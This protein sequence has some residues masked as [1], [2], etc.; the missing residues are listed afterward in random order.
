[1]RGWVV[2]MSSETA[3]M[4]EAAAFLVI[5]A[6]T[7]QAAASLAAGVFAP[8]RA[9]ERRAAAARYARYLTAGLTFQ[10]AAAILEL[11]MAA[12]WDTVERIAVLVA[13]RALLAPLQETGW[14]PLLERCRSWLDRTPSR[15][16]T[17]G[18]RD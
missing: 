12:G 2:V 7:L 5:V 8:Q 18:A 3:A 1:M 10:L 14:A 17:A 9:L 4:I 6:A 11:P 16:E 15:L 13:L